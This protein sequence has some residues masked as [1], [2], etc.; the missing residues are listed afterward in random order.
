M[1]TVDKY[2]T[3]VARQDFTSYTQ[4]FGSDISSQLS[5][6]NLE[7]ERAVA[8]V[9]ADAEEFKMTAA[10]RGREKLESGRYR[11][12]FDL[13]IYNDDEHVKYENYT[14]LLVRDGGRWVI[15]NEE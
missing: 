6:A 10:F 5:E 2:I 3:A 7:A 14:M 4:C 13:T 11:V 1:K 12:I 15:G 9:L 8:D